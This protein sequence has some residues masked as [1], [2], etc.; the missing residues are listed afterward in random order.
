MK[1]VVLS[2]TPKTGLLAVK[3]FLIKSLVYLK[4]II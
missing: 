1:L 2:A 3:E 4:R